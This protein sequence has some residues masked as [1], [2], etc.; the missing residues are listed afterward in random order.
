MNT[1]WISAGSNVGDRWA[2]L[3]RAIAALEACGRVIAVS[4]CYETEPVGYGDQPWFLN[5]AAG[6]ETRLTPHQLLSFC[7][8]IELA[9]GRVRPFPNAPRTLD[10]DILLYGDLILDL[11]D[12]V[13]PHPRLA[14]RR[15]VLEPLAEIAPLLRHPVLNRSVRQLLELCPD[16]ATVRKV[17]TAG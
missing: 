2:Q 12:L 5:L 7:Q 17:E 13:L 1:A 8:S 9:Q 11:P 10:L 4:S 3:G 15:F 6:L 14:D 16:R